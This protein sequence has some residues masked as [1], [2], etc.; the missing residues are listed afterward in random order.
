MAACSSWA[1]GRAQ[2]HPTFLPPGQLP[3]TFPLP[4]EGACLI[5]SRAFDPSLCPWH[6]L[7]ALACRWRCGLTVSHPPSF[8]LLFYFSLFLLLREHLVKGS[9]AFIQETG[10]QQTPA[11]YPFKGVSLE[12]LLL[13]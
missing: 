3:E 5:R 13:L 12:L 11:V 9:S 10:A 4:G 6:R 1:S 8:L 7:T 2:L